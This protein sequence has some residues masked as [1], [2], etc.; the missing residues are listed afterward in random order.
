MPSEELLVFDQLS[1]RVAVLNCHSVPLISTY[2]DWTIAHIYVC[3]WFRHVWLASQVHQ[4][5]Q[6]CEKP[7]H[8]APHGQMRPAL[9]QMD[10]SAGLIREDD[11]CWPNR[12]TVGGLKA[13]HRHH[14]IIYTQ[15]W[16]DKWPTVRHFHLCRCLSSTDL[17]TWQGIKPV[18]FLPFHS[19]R[20]VQSLPFRW[21]PRFL[22]TFP[23]L[24]LSEL[25]WLHNPTSKHL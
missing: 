25:D 2:S 6:R 8:P 4:G 10:A 15:S 23:L 18:D 9:Q 14:T 1:T 24:S 16:L 5:P 13:H 11:Q 12:L 20:L 3:L 17:N 21:L 19:A 7:A 22:K